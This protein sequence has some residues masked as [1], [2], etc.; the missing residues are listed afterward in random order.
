MPEVAHALKALRSEATL[1]F[2]DT[3]ILSY[4]EMCIEDGWTPRRLISQG[5]I[6]D[7]FQSPV[8]FRQHRK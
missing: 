4:D 7:R 6:D 8:T 3:I 1:A 5:H 2:F